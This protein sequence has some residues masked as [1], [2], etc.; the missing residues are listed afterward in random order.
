MGA[1]FFAAGF[2]SVLVFVALELE[3]F[4]VVAVDFVAV[5][6]VPAAVFFLVAVVLSVPALAAVVFFAG[7][8]ASFLSSLFSLLVVSA[9]SFAG[10]FVSLYTDISAE[11]AAESVR[12]V[13]VLAVML[14]GTCY[15]MPCL[16]GLVKSGGDVGFVFKNDTIFVFLVVLPSALIASSLG[17]A[18]WVVFACLKC[19]QILK[20]VVAFIKVNRYN[21]M[22]NLTRAGVES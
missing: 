1:A 2:F 15:Q 20:C 5:V 16:F 9:F 10:A 8:F 14:M 7:V 11:A 17:A 3:A 18:P 22:K 21:W 13:R 4:F 12:F 19:D 6:F